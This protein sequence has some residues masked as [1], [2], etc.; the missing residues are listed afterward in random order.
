[1]ESNSF[2]NTALFRRY[3]RSTQIAVNDPSKQSFSCEDICLSMVTCWHAQY[4]RTSE[5]YM[6]N[7]IFTIFENRQVVRIPS[8]FHVLMKY[9]YIFRHVL[10]GYCTFMLIKTVIVQ[11]AIFKTATSSTTRLNR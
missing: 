4:N 1:M 3:K 7:T 5:S 2:F 9:V 8:I 11:S 6:S 10:L